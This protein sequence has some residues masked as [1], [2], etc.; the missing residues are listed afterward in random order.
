MERVVRRWL[1]PLLAAMVVVLVGCGM[2][3]HGIVAGSPADPIPWVNSPGTAQLSATVHA[4]R[5]C[6]AADLSVKAGKSG[7]FHGMATQEILFTNQGRAACFLPGPPAS[8]VVLG[9]GIRRPVAAGSGPDVASRVDLAV[10]QM[11]QLLIGT[12]GTCSGVGHPQVGSRVD[13]TLAT[14]ERVPVIGTWV[15][16]EC[17]APVVAAFAAGPVPAA[18][19][20][21]SGLLATISGPGSVARGSD[22]QYFITL[23]NPS[24]ASI[25]MSACPSYTETLGVNPATVVRQTLL[26]NC[27][28][29]PAINVG[30][31]VVFEMRL[32]VPAGIP[33]GITKLTWS[34][35]VPNGPSAG[36]AIQLT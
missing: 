30:A 9:N 20:P 5:A 14:G 18:S 23:K 16:V 26:L 35:Q 31:A 32:S 19:V 6:A 8:V 11:A 1:T 34:L 7:A 22:L 15:N 21:A 36:T 29:M 25:T 10:G 3:P 33:S 12:P 24:S 4:S 27:S 2:E 28:A 17:G 13:L